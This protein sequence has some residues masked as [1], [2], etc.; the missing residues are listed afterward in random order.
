MGKKLDKK[1]Q[2]THLAE[3]LRSNVCFFCLGITSTLA[4]NFTDCIFRKTNTK[5]LKFK[6][7][8]LIA[9]CKIAKV[10]PLNIHLLYYI[11]QNPKSVVFYVLFDYI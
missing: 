1:N 2:K 5:C 7:V 10:L 9:Y 6:Q 3:A 8:I 11:N 4:R